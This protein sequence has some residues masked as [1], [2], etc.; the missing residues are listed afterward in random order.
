MMEDT[1][2]KIKYRGFIMDWRIE[3]WRIGM[4]KLMMED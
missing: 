2:L 3:Y 4:N 1:G